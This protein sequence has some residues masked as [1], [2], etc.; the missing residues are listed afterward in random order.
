MPDAITRSKVDALGRRL[1]HS[2]VPLDEDLNL[3]AHFQGLYLNALEA[4]GLLISKVVGGTSGGTFQSISVTASNRV[5]TVDTIIEKL[6][7]GTSLSTMQDVVG[8]RLVAEMTLEIQDELVAALVTQLADCRVVDRRMTPMF[9]YRAVHIIAR[10]EGFPV[11]IQVR[12]ESQDNWAQVME[13]LADEWGRGIR[14][15]EAPVGRNEPERA[16]RAVLVRQ[17]QAVGE[18]IAAAEQA[19]LNAAPAARKA[20]D[21]QARLKAGDEQV[22]QQMLVAAREAASLLRRASDAH[23]KAAGELEAFG[24]ALSNLE[25]NTDG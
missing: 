15:G 20:D 24:K 11:E 3:L 10:V 17:W 2:S 23:L 13:E 8:Y 4:T 14:Y 12:T 1:A 22:K 16:L 7:R 9:G 25:S 19:D 18:A 5:K 6:R 21:L